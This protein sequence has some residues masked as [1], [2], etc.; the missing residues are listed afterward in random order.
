MALYW[1]VN[2]PGFLMRYKGS[3][4]YIP[5][6]GHVKYL[7]LWMYKRLSEE[8]EVVSIQYNVARYIKE[9]QIR[10]NSGDPWC[11]TGLMTSSSMR[12]NSLL[13]KNLGMSSVKSYPS[14]PAHWNV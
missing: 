3:P 10:S 8:S 12:V 2:T 7:Y 14:W 1:V 6:V 9:R 11:K 13:E 5:L 4:S